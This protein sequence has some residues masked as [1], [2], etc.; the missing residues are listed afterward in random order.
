MLLDVNDVALG[1]TT[2][3]TWNDPGKWIWSEKPVSREFDP[4][5]L[6]ATVRE[7]EAAQPDEPKPDETAQ[8]EIAECDA[9][10]RRHRAALE[11]HLS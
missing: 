7:L 9:K 5:A 4:I 1:H 10:L 8:R 3:Q 11:A 2:K 6:P